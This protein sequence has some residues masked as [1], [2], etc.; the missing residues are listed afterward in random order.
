[1]VYYGGENLPGY[2]ADGFGFNFG[3][4]QHA[5]IKLGFR[6]VTC[7]PTPDAPNVRG[8]IKAEK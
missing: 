5:L 6:S 4:L 2:P 7:T 8:I 1:M 3:F